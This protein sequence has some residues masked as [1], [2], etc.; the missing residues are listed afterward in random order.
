MGSTLILKETN[1]KRQLIQKNVCL[2]YDRSKERIISDRNYYGLPRNYIRFILKLSSF[3]V[4][5]L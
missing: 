3:F 2:F 5:T 4:Y 1:V